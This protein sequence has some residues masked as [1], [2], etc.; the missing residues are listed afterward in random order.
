MFA[1]TTVSLS[2][3]TTWEWV[4]SSWT[5][6]GDRSTVAPVINVGDFQCFL[7]RFAAQDGYANCDGSTTAPVLNVSDFSCFV[8]AFAAGP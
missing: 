1:G 4:G 7:N 5:N 2:S 6:R 8:N 3:G